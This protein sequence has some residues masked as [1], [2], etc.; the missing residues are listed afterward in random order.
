MIYPASKAHNISL[1][2][3][4]VLI[5]DRIAS[6]VNWGRTFAECTVDSSLV[7]HLSDEFKSAGYR[8]EITSN[9]EDERLCYLKIYW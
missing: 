1:G 5:K 9:H 8:T 2:R 7:D 3:A 4:R 6:A